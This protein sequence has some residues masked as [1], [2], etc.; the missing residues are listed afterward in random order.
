M[1]KVKI[2]PVQWDEIRANV[3]SGKASAESEA[4]RVGVS[5]SLVRKKSM[6]EGWSKTHRDAHSLEVAKSWLEKAEE[7]RNKMFTMATQALA[8][9]KLPPPKN[10]RDAE[11]ADKI[12]RRAAGLEDGEQG[13]QIVQIALLRGPEP[14]EIDPA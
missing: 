2:T 3:I 14:A 10:W 11:T 13:R 6:R 5:P 12:A 4:K 8:Q 9:A 1:R 7:H